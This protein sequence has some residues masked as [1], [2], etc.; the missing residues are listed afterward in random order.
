MG[1][2]GSTVDIN[3]AKNQNLLT[4]FGRSPPY[5]ISIK[6]VRC[7]LGLIPDLCIRKLE[8]FSNFGGNHLYKIST[9]S[10]SLWNR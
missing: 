8:S 9:K 1:Y 6:S 2:I 5:K 7:K 3:M 10:V 4:I